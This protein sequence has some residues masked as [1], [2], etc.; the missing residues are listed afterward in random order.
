MNVTIVNGT[1]HQ[2]HQNV[3]LMCLPFVNFTSFRIPAVP[4]EII[5]CFHL[6]HPV[7]AVVS[8]AARGGQVLLCSV[9]FKAIKHMAPELGVV[10]HNGVQADRLKRSTSGGWLWRWV[11]I[12]PFPMSACIL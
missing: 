7:S 5:S 8:D 3:S 10:T 4:A 9:T 1:T 12:V 11:R 2:H 6:A